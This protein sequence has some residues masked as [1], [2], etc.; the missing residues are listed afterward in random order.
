M[1]IDRIRTDTFSAVFQ[2]HYDTLRYEVGKHLK[3]EG[4]ETF[5]EL[6]EA[7]KYLGIRWL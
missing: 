6:V 2:E 7:A 5:A 1:A 4:D 3:L